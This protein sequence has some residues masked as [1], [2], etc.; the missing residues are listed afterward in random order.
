VRAVIAGLIVVAAGLGVA[1]VGTLLLE[2][3]LTALAPGGVEVGGLHYNPFTGRL[4]LD[5]LRARDAAG[6]E[7]F[8]AERVIARVN[9]LRLLGRPLTLAYARVTAPRLTLHA[10]AGLDLAELAAELGSAPAAAS[11]LPVRIEDLAIA[12]GSILVEGAG[13]AG[14]PLLVGDLDVRLSRVTTATVAQHD[15]A[16]AVEMAMY[17]AH[18]HVTGQPRGAG[19][20]L[21][22][23]TRALDVAALLRDVPIAGLQGLRRGM[24]EIDAE[25]FV[26]GGRWLASGHARV[27]DVELA[28]PDSGQSRLRAELLAAVVD[29]LDL[30]SGTGRIS[31]LDLVAPRLSLPAARAGRTLAALVEP[32]RSRPELLLRRVTVSRGALALESRE[33]VR[34]EHVQLAAHARERQDSGAWTVTAS[35]KLE[36]DAEVAIDGLLAR[37]L[38]GLDAVARLRRVALGPWRALTGAAGE[39]DARVSFDGH[40]RLAVR[41]GGA[42][43]TLAGDA[44]LADVGAGGGSG[45]RADRIA[46]GIRRLQWPAAHAVVDTV[47]MTRPAFA[48]PAAT[49]W[50]RLLVT[51]NVSV[52]DGELREASE[53]PALHDLAVSLAPTGAAG[54]AHLRLSASMEG[55]RR[56]GIDRIVPFDEPTRGAMPLRLLLAAIQDAARTA[57][58][59]ILVPAPPGTVGPATAEPAAPPAREPSPPEPAAPATPPPA[60]F[61]A[62]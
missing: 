32:L 5:A 19:Y 61:M 24:G 15:V 1:G 45:F 28:L 12:G 27:A 49:P 20:S 8:R 37:D 18:V 22:V 56:L 58:T 26:A 31:R 62:P 14:A 48:L 17:G 4:T 36:P 30:T 38:Y 2:R 25:L 3:R 47:V 54:A 9:P 55:G 21:R 11:T 51:G 23:R 41:E 60:V 57:P 59:P 43:V 33:V 52:V 44:L 29:Y 39:W 46:L 40:L 53:R 7:L 13:E 50:P 35:A 6:R 10:D 42:A 16:F 34:L